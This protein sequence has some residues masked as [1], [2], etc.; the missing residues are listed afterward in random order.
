MDIILKINNSTIKKHINR[1]TLLIAAVIAYKI[2]MIPT[3]NY[4]F[5]YI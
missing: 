5:S 3:S 4:T 2:Y 1:R